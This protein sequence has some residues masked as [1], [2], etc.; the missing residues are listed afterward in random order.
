MA[1][2]KPRP[3]P[4]STKTAPKRPNSA[5]PNLEKALRE[6]IER[7]APALKELEKH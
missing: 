3:A 5:H 6:L 7:R 1:Q 2:P 4:R